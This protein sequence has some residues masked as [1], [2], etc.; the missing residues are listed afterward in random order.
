MLYLSEHYKNWNIMPFKKLI[1]HPKLLQAIE[2]S[3]YTVP[4][5]IQLEAIPKILTGA[6]L[7]ASAQTGTGKT[8]AFLLPSLLRLTQSTP[9]QGQGPRILILVPTREL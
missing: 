3:G 7:Q 6:D 2:E 4:T 9:T 1:S 8:A 5:P